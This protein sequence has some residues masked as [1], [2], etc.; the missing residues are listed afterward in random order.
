MKKYLWTITLLIVL[1]LVACGGKEEEPA[2]TA[3]PT[4]APAEIEATATSEPAPEIETVTIRF[5]VNDIQQ[6]L[7]R[8]MIADF[9]EENPEIEI[10]LVSIE[11][12]L[13]LDSLAAEWPDDAFLRLVS[14]ADVINV[15]ASRSAI[16]SG[17]ILDLAPLIE[18]SSNAN[19][20]DFFPGTLSHCQWDGG[21]WCLPTT[22]NFQ[23]IFFNRD[24]FDEVGETYPEPGWTWDDFLDKATALT[25]REGTRC[26]VGV[27]Y[28]TGT[29]TPV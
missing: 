25:Q 12:V 6:G 18:S 1:L 8:E 17:L 4:E 10:K 9:Q 23:F 13:E 7:Y 5:A 22:A 26:C 3:P 14:A 24:A 28:R 19:P 29:A 11:E 20:E 21:T 15:Q 2:A 27:S 16:E